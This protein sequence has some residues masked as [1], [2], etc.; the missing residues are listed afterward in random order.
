MCGQTHRWQLPPHQQSAGPQT[1]ELAQAQG[2]TEFV[3][4]ER[5]YEL[6]GLS[7][8]G[9]AVDLE[10]I[11]RLVEDEELAR[12]DPQARASALNVALKA[13][14]VEL[15][16]L[17]AIAGRRDLALDSY[18]ARLEKHVEQLA[19][20][21]ASEQRRLEQELEEFT[22]RQQGLI[23]KARDKEQEV[24]RKLGEFKSAKQA[25]E[26]RLFELMAQFVAPGDNPVKLEPRMEYDESRDDSQL[27]KQ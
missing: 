23:S 21:C 4:V 18:E 6:A 19:G 20:E 1:G 22:R 26:R 2:G 13:I 12:L 25:E 24:R 3:S 7:S 11:A 16:E 27:S 14:G 8:S 17:L 15:A 5:V 9:S 10:R